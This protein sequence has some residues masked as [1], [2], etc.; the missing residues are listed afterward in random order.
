MEPQ[1]PSVT[2]AAELTRGLTRDDLEA[3]RQKAGLERLPEGS[4]ADA[5][6]ERGFSVED[7]VTLLMAALVEKNLDVQTQA[8]EIDRLNGLCREQRKAIDQIADQAGRLKSVLVSLDPDRARG[9]AMEHLKALAE[10]PGRGQ[11]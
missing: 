2:V 5:L 10:K 9:G 11:G 1:N 8:R 3:L 4:L 6:S 7:L